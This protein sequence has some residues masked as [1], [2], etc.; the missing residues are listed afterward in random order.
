MRRIILGLLVAAA[1]F[2]ATAEIRVVNLDKNSNVKEILGNDTLT[3][4]SL[5]VN[6]YLSHSNLVPISWMT[7]KRLRYLDMCECVIENNTIPPYGLNPDPYTVISLDPLIYKNALSEVKL[8]PTLE[9]IEEFAF[10]CTLLKTIDLPKSM[11]YIGPFA[12][13]S[14][15]KLTG[16]LEL[17]D[18][19]ELIDE[20]AFYYANGITS[21][22]LPESIKELGICAFAGLIGMTEINFPDGLT[23]IGREA[24]A[25]WYKYGMQKTVLPASLATLSEKAFIY[26]KLNNVEFNKDC[27]LQEIGE[28]SFLCCHL[29]GISLPDNCVTIGNRA[30]ESNCLTELYLPDNIQFIGAGAFGS[31]PYLEK[32]V[33]SGKTESIGN[34]AFASCEKLKSVYIKALS[35]A[36]I[37]SDSFEYPERMTLYVPEGA[38]AAYEA[39]N[40]WKDFGV[41]VEVTEFPSAGHEAVIADGAGSG[42]AFGAAGEAVVEGDDVPYAIFSTD[43]TEAASGVAK[44][45]TTIPLPAGI[46]VARIGGT[47]RRIAVR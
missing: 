1:T 29:S 10:A 9:R 45:R 32:I 18:G 28:K 24:C 15:H 30:F 47:S 27:P 37:A 34:S 23:T 3:I 21:I 4:D 14:C 44:G 2:V 13:D 42:R 33:L 41:I 16:H 5:K 7:T 43:G 26:S 35:P 6:G 20:R 31:N 39:A 46:Y 25:G 8:P 36:E 12:F 22:K 17:P 11:K 38:K 40:H 19:I